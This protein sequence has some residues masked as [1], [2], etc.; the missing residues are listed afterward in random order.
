MV[1]SRRYRVGAKCRGMYTYAAS[2]AEGTGNK[3]GSLCPFH[4][5]W[6]AGSIGGMCVSIPRRQRFDGD[7]GSPEGEAS[8]ETAEAERSATSAVF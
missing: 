1:V 7:T 5:L 6:H 8:I 3:S 2:V 4:F